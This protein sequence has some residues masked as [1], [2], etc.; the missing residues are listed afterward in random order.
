MTIRQQ[1]QNRIS[2]MTV[3]TTVFSVTTAEMNSVYCDCFA[4]IDRYRI[5]SIKVN[6]RRAIS[7]DRFGNRW[8]RRPVT[9][10]ITESFAGT[11]PFDLSWFNHEPTRRGHQHGHDIDKI[12]T[13]EYLRKLH[14]SKW[15]EQHSTFGIFFHSDFADSDTL[16]EN[17]VDQIIYSDLMEETLWEKDATE[18]KLV[19]SRQHRTD[20]EYAT[21]EWID[22]NLTKCSDC[23]HY[24]VNADVTEIDSYSTVCTNCLDNYSTCEECR[25]W[26]H[27]DNMR[28]CDRSGE[29]VCESCYDN[30]DDEEEYYQPAQHDRFADWTESRRRLT[31]YP[32]PLAIEIEG[33]SNDSG[34]DKHDRLE[35]LIDAMTAAAHDKW[36]NEGLTYTR[37]R[38]MATSKADGSLSNKYGFELITQYNRF[39]T[40]QAMLTDPDTVRA[41]ARCFDENEMKNNDRIGL[42]V[43][44]PESE[45]STLA[46]YRM[47]LVTQYLDN[48]GAGYA[49]ELFGRVP[50]AYHNNS[51]R[52]PKEVASGKLD[53]HKTGAVSVRNKHDKKGSTPSERLGRIEIR[54]PRS[55][56]TAPSLLARLELI[57]GLIIWA[58]IDHASTLNMTPQE[59]WRA[60]ID[61]YSANLTEQAIRAY[62]RQLATV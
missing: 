53:G 58:R 28:Y 3:S 62:K 4:G 22:E 10:I 34:Q 14:I 50:S 52:C 54:F 38:Y 39:E 35:T 26:T 40:I 30:R 2:T 60:F 29:S 37:G 51:A 33:E 48:D 45:I 56:W 41:Y 11:R 7:V 36:D 13:Q 20:T 6:L 5:D 9:E 1:T 32:V 55:A 15:T 61:H 21:D 44:F 18:I 19:V 17:L 43:S 47:N 16:Q 24:Q 59:A 49:R 27:S 8:D 42:H 23:G 25:E 57:M 31:A 12:Y 46:R